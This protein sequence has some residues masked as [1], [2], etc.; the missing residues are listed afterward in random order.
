MDLPTQPSSISRRELNQRARSVIQ[1]LS[2]DFASDNYKTSI[3]TFIYDT[4]WVSMIRKTEGGVQRWLFP[5]AF[6]FILERQLLDGGWQSFPLSPGEL[7]SGI[8][9]IVNTMAAILALKTRIAASSDDVQII[10][11]RISRGVTALCRMLQSWDF[12]T[13]DTVA[14][15]VI[16]PAHLEMLERHGLTFQFDGRALLM[17][18]YQ[19][20]MGKFR[21]EFLYG[22]DPTSLVYCMEAFIG[23]VNFDRVAHHRV[24]GGMLTSPSSTAAYLMNSSQWDDEAESYLRN[25]IVDGG[26]PEPYPSK[27]YEITWVELTS[28]SSS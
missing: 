14:F 18:S 28:I 12:S 7:A 11:A 8:D 24:N 9:G 2:A 20:R 4:A 22:K 1:R 17:K 6:D 26:F 3:T 23:K 25:A 16:V 19:Q 10:A 27:I 15:E 5:E 13:T 21:P